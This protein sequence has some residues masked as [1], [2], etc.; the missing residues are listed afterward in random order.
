MERDYDEKCIQALDDMYQKY[1]FDMYNANILDMI[2]VVKKE[3]N[4]EYSEHLMNTNGA[5]MRKYRFNELMLHAL[6]EEYLDLIG[7]HNIFLA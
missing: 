1:G 6:E 3:L 2:E 5:Y 7:K 4:V